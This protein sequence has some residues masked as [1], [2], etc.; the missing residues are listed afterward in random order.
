[1]AVRAR[2]P[3]RR[4]GP[5]CCPGLRGRST[6]ISR[7]ETMSQIIRPARSR[8]TGPPCHTTSSRRSAAAKSLQRGIAGQASA[9]VSKIDTRV[10]ALRRQDARENSSSTKIAS[11]TGPA[12]LQRVRVQRLRAAIMALTC[13]LSTSCDITSAQFSENRGCQRQSQCYT[14]FHRFSLTEREAVPLLRPLGGRDTAEQ[15]G[16]VADRKAS[17]WAS[18]CCAA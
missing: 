6:S 15:L 3:G 4:A 13:S 16:D 14:Q 10:G 8:R 12:N 5:P 11:S 18:R 9:G 2:T 17:C 1:M 7:S